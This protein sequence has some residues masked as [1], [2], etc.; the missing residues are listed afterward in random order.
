MSAYPDSI[1]SLGFFKSDPIS[2]N[3]FSFNFFFLKS[4]YISKNIYRNRNERMIFAPIPVT[5]KDG[6]GYK[7][8]VESAANTNV[9]I[10]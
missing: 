8:T 2:K 6:M 3:I 5:L 1:S 7:L 9:P 4:D 10:S